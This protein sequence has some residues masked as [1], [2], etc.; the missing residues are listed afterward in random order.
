CVAAAFMTLLHWLARSADQ[1]M[2]QKPQVRRDH[3]CARSR[4]V[5]NAAATHLPL[6]RMANH[7]TTAL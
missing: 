7:F 1:R 2:L 4:S 5:M 3:C 6:L